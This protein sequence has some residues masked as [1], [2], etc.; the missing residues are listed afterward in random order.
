MHVTTQYQQLQP[1][2][3][4]IIANLHPQ[5]STIRAVAR[6]V[7]RSLATVSAEL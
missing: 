4:L 7:G 2:E 5:G 6:I 3:R 1:E